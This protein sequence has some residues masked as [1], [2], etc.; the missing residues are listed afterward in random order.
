MA[1]GEGTVQP[2]VN[3]RLENATARLDAQNPR[4]Y[5]GRD[6]SVCALV[7]LH[8]SVSR[9]HAELF[10][11]NGQ[12]YLRDLGSSNGTW[13]DGA[14]VGQQPIAL[15]P[16]HT[17]YVGYMPLG[18]EWQGANGGATVMA[19]DVPAELRAMIEARK[20]QAMS[21][22]SQVPGYS[23]Q[24]PAQAGYSGQMPAQSGQMPAQAGYSGQMSAQ[25]PAQSG[26]MPAQSGGAGL[27]QHLVYRRQGTNQNGVLLIALPADTFTNE[28]VI[29]G[30]VEFTSMD[31][32][33][34]DSITVELI[35]MHE[36]G[37]RHGHVW[38]RFLVRQGPWKSKR[39]DVLP[40]PFQLRVPQGTSVSGRH[41]EWHVRGYVDIAWAFDIEAESPINMRNMDVEKIR[42]AMGSIDYRVADIA[43]SPLGQHHVCIF[44][45]PAQLQ[46]QLGIREVVTTMEY[47][48]QNLKVEL[49]VDKQKHFV[50][51]PKKELLIDLG[52][53]RQTPEE[54][55]GRDFLA[56][57]QQMMG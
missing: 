5:I 23:G 47:L 31:A 57:I 12:L 27:P 35:E 29:E 32:E 2:T 22:Q 46:T 26:Q 56:N 8:P 13:V 28:T 48:G 33:R 6:N 9:R 30:F 20:Q 38:D 4:L 37:P 17:V 10:L 34:V 53:F 54:Q 51:D 41:V 7:A 55:I 43:S 19:V 45:P 44:Q 36:K 52:R 21:Q 1:A 25:M 24:M 50:K 16:G 49:K 14:A 15:M 11:D 40:M 42:D 18:V 39:G 3:L